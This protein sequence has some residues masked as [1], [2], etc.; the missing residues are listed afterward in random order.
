[1]LKKEQPSSNLKQ[2]KVQ[3]GALKRI[4]K[5]LLYYKKEYAAQEA[6]IAKLVADG[7]DEHDVRKQQEVLEETNQMLPDCRR[8]ITSAHND[9]LSTL[10]Q[11]TKV[12][13]VDLSS[14]EIVAARAA[15]DETDLSA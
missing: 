6:R 10:N 12:N 15:I 9:L 2:L 4:N 11:I 8:R 7:A 14:E 3:T 13:D 1:M 5:D